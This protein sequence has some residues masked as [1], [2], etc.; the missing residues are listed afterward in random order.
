MGIQNMSLTF[1]RTLS[2]VTMSEE[3]HMLPL[4]K[5]VFV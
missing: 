1:Y 3:A 5:R 2:L 4:S